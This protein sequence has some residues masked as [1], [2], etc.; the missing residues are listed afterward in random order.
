MEKVD[1]LATDSTIKMFFAVATSHKA[2]R[3]R[4]S[5]ALELPQVGTGWENTQ[6]MPRNNLEQSNLIFDKDFT[7][8][9]HRYT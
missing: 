8:N 3:L 9:F 2:P 4:S 1:L 6:I 7:T 5:P